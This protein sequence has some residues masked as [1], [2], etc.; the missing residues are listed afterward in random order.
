MSNYKYC[1]VPLCTSTTKSAPEKRFF[2]VPRSEDIRK[3]WMEKMRRKDPVSSKS[4]VYC[5]EDHFD[6]N[7]FLLNIYFYS[8]II[9]L[10]QIP[11][12]LITGGAKLKPSVI[13]H[14]FQCQQ[15][16]YGEQKA[17]KRKSPRKRSHPQSTA[18]DQ[19]IGNYHLYSFTYYCFYSWYN[20]TFQT[21]LM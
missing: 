5:C 21:Q 6:V 4:N 10:F 19:E 17:P 18:A 3:S 14:R 11:S 2:S 15:S 8:T 16:K 1:V 20:F 7:I 13:P 12:D 9:M